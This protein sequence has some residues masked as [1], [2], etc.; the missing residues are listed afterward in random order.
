VRRRNL[1]PGI[2]L[3]AL[4]ILIGLLACQGPTPSPSA[5]RGR[6]APTSPS[7]SPAPASTP[8]PPPYFV[9]ALRARPYPGGRIQIGEVMVRDQG[10]TRY[11]MSWPAE[12]QVMTGTIAIPDG[13][14]PFPVVL[15]EHGFIPPERYWV[16]QDSAIFGDPMAAH[17]FLVVAPNW[18]GYAGSGPGPP[19]LPPIVGELV[20][21]LDLVSS[22]GT[23]P[24][25][26]VS[27]IACVGHSNGGGICE[28]AMVV[29]PRIG[30]V[31]LQAPISSDMADNART[32]WD[33]HPEDLG[34]LGTPD[35]DPQGY[36][37]LSPRN[38]FAPGQAPVLIVQGTA[39]HTIPAVWTRAT[40]DAL[41]QRGVT[42]RLLWIP[43]GDHDLVG[44]N[45]ATAVAAQEAWIR[46]AFH[47]G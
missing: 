25:A 14:G 2:T 8:A 18:P 1:G 4:L 29:D 44:A 6:P 39:D 17:G 34:T 43:G 38:Y 21:A 28:L 5:P 16:G 23:L 20:T 41:A 26:D 3:T 46:Q 35:T 45:L 32:W 30:A 24:Q 33:Q 42:A 36:Q 12:G 15:V 47:L 37:H 22:L 19:G 10:F 9:E 11:R 31:V 13:T 27:H 40:Y 7:P